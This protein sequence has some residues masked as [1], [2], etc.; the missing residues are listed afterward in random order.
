MKKIE[1]VVELTGIGRIKDALAEAGIQRMSLGE[2]ILRD[3]RIGRHCVYRGREFADES[4][5]HARFGLVLA[6]ALVDRAVAAIIAAARRLKLTVSDTGEAAEHS[7]RLGFYRGHTYVIPS[8]GQER[9][10]M[11]IPETHPGHEAANITMTPEGVR[12]SMTD[13]EDLST[14]EHKGIY[15]GTV[16][17]VQDAH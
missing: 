15:R 10:E 8:A 6:D 3:E 13:V 2:T 17:Q 14:T 12:V 4:V 11:I 7:Q 9:I 16:Y 5:A 1:A